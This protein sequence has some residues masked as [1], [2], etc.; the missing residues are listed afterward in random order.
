MNPYKVAFLLYNTK[1]L[2]SGALS[3]KMLL[4]RVIEKNKFL[5]ILGQVR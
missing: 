4:V 1:K 3:G 5:L 2:G